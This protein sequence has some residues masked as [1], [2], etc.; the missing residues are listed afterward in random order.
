MQYSLRMTKKDVRQLATENGV[1]IRSSQPMLAIRREARHDD[2]DVDDVVAGHAMHYSALGYT[3]SEIAQVLDLS[4]RQ[5][6]DIGKAYRF[7]FRQQRE[8]DTP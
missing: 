7:E 2:T 3:V 4:L 6:W 1:R 5:V 8:S